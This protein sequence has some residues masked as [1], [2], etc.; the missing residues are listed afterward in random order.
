[1]VLDLFFYDYS[2]FSLAIT[3]CLAFTVV[4]V[5]ALGLYLHRPELAHAGHS[6]NW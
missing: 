6:F 3:G 1:M 2:Y 5:F 4:F